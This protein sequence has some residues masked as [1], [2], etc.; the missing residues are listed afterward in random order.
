MAPGWAGRGDVD[1]NGH[2]DQD[3]DSV[4]KARGAKWVGAGRISTRLDVY[5]SV[6]IWGKEKPKPAE[7]EHISHHNFALPTRQNN[8]TWAVQR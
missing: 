5:L 8:T 4:E 2:A 7:S 6:K 1:E 3:S